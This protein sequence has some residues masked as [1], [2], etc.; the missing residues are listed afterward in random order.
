[1]SL[2]YGVLLR[3]ATSETICGTYVGFVVSGA[4]TYKHGNAVRV[5]LSGNGGGKH[6]ENPQCLVGF[7]LKDFGAYSDGPGGT[8]RLLSSPSCMRFCMAFANCL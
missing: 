6:R 7:S 5:Y 1:M 2:V 3:I 8:G 4:V